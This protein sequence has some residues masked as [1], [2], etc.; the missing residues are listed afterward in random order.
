M[1]K[2]AIVEQR[3]YPK[4]VS[5]TIIYISTESNYLKQKNYSKLLQF[6]YSFISFSIFVSLT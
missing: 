5:F 4:L 1:T 6:S 3:N 2:L